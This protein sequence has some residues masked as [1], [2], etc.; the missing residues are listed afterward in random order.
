MTKSTR[1]SPRAIP[2]QNAQRSPQP[3]PV[4]PAMTG[5]DL[6]LSSSMAS[7]KCSTHSIPIQHSCDITRAPCGPAEGKA[8][9]PYCQADL[10]I[11]EKRP[12]LKPYM[13]S[14]R[15]FAIRRFSS[16]SNG[17]GKGRNLTGSDC[18]NCFRGDTDFKAG[19]TETR[20]GWNT[21]WGRVWTNAIRA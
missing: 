18:A 15:E 16:G 13:I 9:L 1:I 14:V 19:S 7:S 21:V 8:D 3:Q 20:S 12:C 6:L 10:L 17:S 4:Y 2:Q 11:R 5:L